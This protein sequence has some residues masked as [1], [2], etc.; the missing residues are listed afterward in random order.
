MVILLSAMSLLFLTNCISFSTLQSVETLEPGT[1]SISAGMAT[2][3]EDGEPAGIL[4]ELGMRYGLTDRIDVGAKI[5]LPAALFIDTKVE[6]IQKPVTVSFD[7]GYSMLQ[8]NSGSGESKYQMNA[9]YPMLMVGQ[10]HWYVG[11]KTI[12]VATDGD[13]N[14]FG[15]SSDATESLHFANDFVMGVVVGKRLRL[16]PEVNILFSPDW[17]TSIVIPAMG[18]ELK[19]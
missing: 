13:F 7:L 14:V 15:T 11:Y 2:L 8:I 10:K 5:F 17:E 1:V 3:V 16:L 4:P 19:F 18:V 12:F 6:L 9:L